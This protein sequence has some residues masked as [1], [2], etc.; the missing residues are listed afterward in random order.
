M[1]DRLKLTSSLIR[2]VVYYPYWMEMRN[3]FDADIIN[4]F[5]VDKVG[6]SDKSYTN[7]LKFQCYY[8]ISSWY[9][10]KK[11]SILTCVKRDTS[12]IFLDNHSDSI[13]FAGCVINN[14]KAHSFNYYIESA[15][16]NH[17]SRY[18]IFS[19]EPSPLM[20]DQ[21]LQKE[22]YSLLQAAEKC[23]RWNVQSSARLTH[24]DMKTGMYCESRKNGERPKNK[25]K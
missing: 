14:F 5:E 23:R 19:S 21:R 15:F 13:I 16:A 24:V 10:E 17:W 3:F 11:K 9:C 8:P 20:L 4:S 18:S 1:G 22:M 7:L 12:C 2:T 6:W 25:I